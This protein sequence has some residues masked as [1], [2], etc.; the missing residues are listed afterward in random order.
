VE[1]FRD[2]GPGPHVLAA[3]QAVRD[4]GLEPVDGPFGTSVEAEEGLIHPLLGQISAA[5]SR[6]GATGVRMSVHRGDGNH[7]GERRPQ[8]ATGSNL[9]GGRKARGPFPLRQAARRTPA[10]RA[11]RL[12]STQCRRRGRRCHGRQPRHHLQL[13]RRRKTRRMNHP[14]SPVDRIA[15]GDS[16]RLSDP[17]LMSDIRMARR[18]GAPVVRTRDE[19]LSL[20]RRP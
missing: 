20:I 11:R 18:E 7:G 17:G 6:A 1:P 5:A 14:P 19:A 4:A 9:T 16:A 3:V 15:G 12:S 10:V 13:P 8:I 2:G